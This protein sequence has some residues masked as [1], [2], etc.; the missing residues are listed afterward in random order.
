MEWMDWKGKRIFVRL[1]TG[2]VY[3]G[4][5]RDID[6]NSLPLIFISIIDKFGLLVTFT[7]GEIIEIKEEKE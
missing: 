4:T 3:S 6:M 7:S 5:V 1:R 2:K